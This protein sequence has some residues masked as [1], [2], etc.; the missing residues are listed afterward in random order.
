MLFACSCI[1]KQVVSRKSFLAIFHKGCNAGVIYNVNGSQ[2]RGSQ[3][4]EGHLMKT[5]C[6]E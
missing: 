3:N 6:N 4:V 5:K 1:F 2:D